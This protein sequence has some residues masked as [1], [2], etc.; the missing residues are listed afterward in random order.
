MSQSIIEGLQDYFSECPLLEEMSDGFID[1]TS[2][3]A[4]CYGIIT[5]GDTEIK[6]FISGGGKREYS[7]TLQIRLDAEDKR[8]VKNPEWTEK[9]KQWCA[10]QNAA[11][12]FPGM[13]EGCVPTK[14]SAEG[15]VLCERDR[16]GRTGL[17]KI[18]FRL[19]YIKN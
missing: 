7:F 17:Y 9:M 12:N 16:T 2:D 3:A 10:A 5:D 15:G 1:W 6:K 19:N 18:R 8:S 13:P 4:G 11:K 14:I